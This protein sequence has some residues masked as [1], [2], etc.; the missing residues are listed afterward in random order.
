[1]FSVLA[2]PSSA[3]VTGGDYKQPFLTTID[4]ER[5][6]ALAGLNGLGVGLAQSADQAYNQISA[7]NG[8]LSTPL[9]ISQAATDLK[10]PVTAEMN[11]ATTDGTSVNQAAQTAGSAFTT[12]Y[13]A[14][15]QTLL[16]RSPGG[17]PDN[18]FQNDLSGAF[19]Q[20]NATLLGAFSRRP[21]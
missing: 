1:M 8:A 6:S 20:V 10:T 21:G 7:A 13:N 4:Q 16:T 12:L 18:Q 5:Q 11:A 19:N 3:A 14:A 15:W 2:P 17:A 9:D